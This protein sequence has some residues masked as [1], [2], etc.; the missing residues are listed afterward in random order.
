MNQGL[1]D[2]LHVIEMHW[3][4]PG[5]KDSIRE[6]AYQRAI[7]VIKRYNKPI[8]NENLKEVKKLKGIGKNIATKIKQYIDNGSIDKADDYRIEDAGAS[9]TTYEEGVKEDFKNV[10]GVGS[11]GSTKLWDKG[12]RS[13]EEL[14]ENQNLLTKQQK[15]GLKYYE[16]F[17]KRVSRKYIT[18]LSVAIQYTL[19]KAYG[20]G[21]FKFMVGGSYRRGELT[22]GDMDCVLA[23]T[24][25]TPSE[26]IS[27]LQKAGFIT[28]ILSFK[29]VK[30]MGVVHCLSPDSQFV[31]LDIAFANED[32]WGAMV[33]YFTG[34]KGLNT[35][36]RKVAADKGMT[37][38]E[39][40]LWKGP[41][42]EEN[43]VHV[44][45]EREIFEELGYEYID[46]KL[47]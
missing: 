18:I 41:I 33:L 46:P 44:Y 11:V 35:E 15:I 29:N 7:G 23:S 16:D 38:N 20:V 30:F 21:S 24:V 32:N 43:R 6:Q 3:K 36:M 39:Y 14:R 19:G 27:T 45:T 12:I 31:R 9:H 42:K 2:D 28:E 47:R 1:I 25:F 10:W 13:I 4:R 34:S 37:L 26:A 40:G 22:S 5:T 17:R 8:T